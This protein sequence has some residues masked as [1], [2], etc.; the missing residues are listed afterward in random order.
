MAALKPEKISFVSSVGDGVKII[1]F[2]YPSS[3][4][5]V[6]GVVQICHGMA[7]YLERY[8]DMIFMLNEARY[9]VCGMDMP[10]H[11]Q[12]YYMNKSAGHPLGYF[13]GKKNAYGMLLADEMG[14]HEY[15]VK[16]FGRK[17]LKYILYGHSMGSFVVRN[18]FSTPRYNKQFD[19]YVF[20]STMGKNSLLGFGKFL[21]NAACILGCKKR[22]NKL[23]SAL[24]FGSYLKRI[25]GAKTTYDWLSTDPEV[26]QKFIDDPLCKFYFTSDGFRT[27]FNLIG[28]MQSKEAY[29]NVPADRPCLFAYSTEDP[30]GSYAA[31]VEKVIEKMKASGADLK[32]INYGPYRH[33]LMNEPAIKEQYFKD[34]VDFYDALPLA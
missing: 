7:E 17:D 13:G 10:G 21:A 2:F 3:A 28:F 16:R 27:L 18:I 26:V 6:K 30:V 14:L 29:A 9:H 12:T 8:R 24:S 5:K 31:G 20:S 4:K 33:E 15:A 19:G 32:A 1:G 25:K 34:L 11:G 22:P 23:L